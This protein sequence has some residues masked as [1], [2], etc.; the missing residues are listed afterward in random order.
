M[1]KAIKVAK[2][3]R[4][5]RFAR[6]IVLRY[7]SLCIGVWKDYVLWKLKLKKL[8]R[9]VMMSNKFIYFEMFCNQV[10]ISIDNRLYPFARIIQANLRGFMVRLK[11]ARARNNLIR[12]RLLDKWSSRGETLS[13]IQK[14][15]RGISARIVCIF[16]F[17]QYS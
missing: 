10:D 5:K 7:A 3:N 9:R 2:E 1:V 14:W 6:R 4:A 13:K 8:A 17:S 11:Q 12:K 16:V 15:W